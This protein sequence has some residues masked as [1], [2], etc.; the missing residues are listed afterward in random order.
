M[1]ITNESEPSA[2]DTRMIHA[3]YSD[4]EGRAHDG[5]NGIALETESVVCASVDFNKRALRRVLKDS[6]LWRCILLLHMRPLRMS[7]DYGLA[8]RFVGLLKQRLLC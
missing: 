8:R 6:F 2:A 7:L 1:L 3:D 5:V 4:T